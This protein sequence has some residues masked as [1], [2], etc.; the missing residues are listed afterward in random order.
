MYNLKSASYCLY[1][2]HVLHTGWCHKIAI[3]YHAMRCDAVR[4][5]RSYFPT[6]CIRGGPTSAIVRIYSPASVYWESR[7]APA[8][9]R[10]IFCTGWGRGADKRCRTVR[11]KVR[12]RSG[13]SARHSGSQWRWTG[14]RL[15]TIL[16]HWSRTLRSDNG[17]QRVTPRF[18]SS[19]ALV[20]LTDLQWQTSSVLAQKRR[21]VAA[22]QTL[23]LPTYF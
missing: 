4:P 15:A 10:H 20:S 21:R 13:G 18:N 1:H 9:V 6:R 5:L 17:V 8:V 7:I 12:V 19:Q 14:V 3:W 22:S 16:G 11:T 2:V 23:N